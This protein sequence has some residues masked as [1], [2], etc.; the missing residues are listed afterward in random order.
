MDETLALRLAGLLAIA[1]SLMYMVGDSLLLAVRGRPDLHPR[2]TAHSKLL[3]GMERL[4]DIDPR[5][6]GPGGL[7]GVF[8]TP[9]V[10]L[11]WWPLWH[12]LRPA[13]EIAAFGPVL[14]FA[15]GSVIGAFV[16]GWFMALP[17]A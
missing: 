16:H 11:G 6:I 2:L 1:G 13:G 9:F 15:I 10:L 5:R 17:G 14:L 3:G 4:A 12:G 7:L 8:G